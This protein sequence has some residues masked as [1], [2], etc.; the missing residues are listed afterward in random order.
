M[1]ECEKIDISYFEQLRKHQNGKSE[2]REIKIGATIIIRSYVQPWKKTEWRGGQAKSM[3]EQAIEYA[4]Y[5][6]L[7]GVDHIWIYINEA[8]NGGKDLP[9]RDYISWVPSD[10][11]VY[12]YR[13]FTRFPGDQ[14]YFETFRAAL[15]SD[16][17]SR[18][19]RE[20]MDW[21][22][23]ND[24]DEYVRIGPSADRQ[25]PDGACGVVGSL[26]R[27]MR[28]YTDMTDGGIAKRYK[29]D[30]SS[31][32]GI[33][34][35]SVYYGMNKK[36]DQENEISLI[37]DNVWRKK[38]PADFKK[39]FFEQTHRRK[40]IVDPSKALTVFIHDVT[41]SIEPFTCC[42]GNDR[43]SH[44]GL[45]EIEEDDVIRVNHYKQPHTGVQINEKQS[46]KR[47]F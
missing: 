43:K 38:R 34:L 26:T 4:E 3:R 24:V 36:V 19:R 20:G 11:N 37:I 9:H 40:M 2:K 12:N 44:T 28:N 31:M 39:S 7:L 29:E 41:S 21:I 27:F 35:E 17:L 15:Q 22:V 13:N 25:C 6:H 47:E 1:D 42:Q 32:A 10:W 5:H 30:G 33:R 18:A 23:M 16:A 14:T 8:W 45:I 46:H